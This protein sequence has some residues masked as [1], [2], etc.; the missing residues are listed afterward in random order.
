MGG[1][2]IP[3]RTW[4]TEGSLDRVKTIFGDLI[5]AT[6]FAV[7]HMLDEQKRRAAKRIG[8]I[9]EAARSAA[10]SLE[11]SED[12]SVALYANRA[13]DQIDQVVETVRDGENSR[14]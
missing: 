13:A 9:A 5:G 6:R 3:A 8:G 4:E 11:R 10:H 12:S 2:G 7:E 1:A 14:P